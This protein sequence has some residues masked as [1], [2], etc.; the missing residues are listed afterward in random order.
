MTKQINE[1]FLLIQLNSIISILFL[2]T[3]LIIISQFTLDFII[4]RFNF[5]KLL[6]KGFYSFV[7]MSL[8]TLSSFY[9]PLG[10]F[11]INIIDRP[12]LDWQ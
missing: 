11:L 3:I 8:G 1:V 5:Y 4:F 10:Y 6:I 7:Y 12:F 2:I 9:T